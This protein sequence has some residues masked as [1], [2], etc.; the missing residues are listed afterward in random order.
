MIQL[1]QIRSFMK[2]QEDG[3]T[4]E[5]VFDRFIK[6]GLH[7]ESV[8]ELFRNL[9]KYLE[10]IPKG[11]DW[12][13]FYTLANCTAK[14]REFQSLSVMFFDIDGIDVEQLDAYIDIVCNTLK[15]KKEE[16]GI[17]FSGNGLHFIIGLAVPIVD[18]NFYKENKPHY[19]AILNKLKL[20]IEEKNLPLG[21]VDPS[22]FDARRFFRLPGTINRKPGKPERVAK[23]LYS[24]IVPTS[25]DIT[26]FSGIP[27]VASNEQ[28][29]PK[30][31]KNFQK[32]DNEAIFKGCA[33][34]RD[35]RDYPEKVPEYAWYAALSITARMENGHEV[36]HKIS[37]GHPSYSANET[38][39]KI[40]QALNAS[41]PRTCKSIS[42]FSP[43]CAKCPFFKN[44]S[45]P[46]LIRNPDAIKTEHTGFHDYVYDEET[47]KMKRG[48]PNYKDLR[49]FFE[50]HHIYRSHDKMVWAW[51]GTHY[52]EMSNEEIKNFAQKHFDPY[53]NFSMRMEFLDLVQVT[54]LVKQDVWNKGTFGKIN[55]KNGIL[56]LAK[57]ELSPHS[58]DSGFKY[59]LPYDYDEK[60]RAPRFEQ[61]LREVTDNNQVLIDSLLEFGGYALSGSRCRYHKALVLDGEGKNGKSTFINTLKEVAGEQSYSA[62][63][64]KELDNI[65]RRSALDGVLFNITEETPNKIFDTASFK[66]LISG[67]SLPVRKLYK[68]SYSIIN[69]AK[70]IFS[71]N[72]MPISPD[73][74]DGFFRRLLIIPFKVKFSK[75]DGN[76]D[77]AIEDKLKLETP[78][79]LNLFLQ[80][81]QRLI[82]Q[83]G[84]TKE[85]QD[86]D[87]DLE[88]FKD[89]TDPIKQWVEEQ[90][91]V[92]P[93]NEQTQEYTTPRDLF[94]NFKMWCES[95]G[96]D[97]RNKNS[98]SL[99]KQML[100][101]IPTIEKRR[102]RTSANVR[103]ILGIQIK[104]GMC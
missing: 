87:L 18:K 76:L 98:A 26:L 104:E 35:V 86:R 59:C 27:I 31:L 57:M 46:I 77:T 5:V 20:A 8:P 89:A 10:Q 6:D 42:N 34:L 53:A 83:N 17:V 25:F 73:G 7:A 56:D 69:K 60:A 67:G 13:C 84:F 96:F 95:N 15:I 81:Y 21:K 78:G 91:V 64:F 23:L 47:G 72:E 97:P 19:K 4:E 52:K 65:E 39:L 66:N 54:N 62:L 38:D 85:M 74:S 51:T 1:L 11:E 44:A 55:L 30:S 79:I 22:V 33:F 48:K 93:F 50:R 102:R 75:E 101:Y 3:T 43:H 2:K 90:I 61:F 58:K 94:L 70:L 12:N 16:T 40:E 9:P 29:D 28:V 14:K 68:N 100:R 80:G 32:P 103:K 82:K 36:S 41:G 37:K 99:S 88:Q 45:S 71:C 63:S 92:L 49:L 24:S